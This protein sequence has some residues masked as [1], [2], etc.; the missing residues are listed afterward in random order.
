M[1]FEYDVYLTLS[2]AAVES[3]ADTAIINNDREMQRRQ[4]KTRFFGFSDGLRSPAII[5][6]QD[7]CFFFQMY[8][9]E[10]RKKHCQAKTE[11]DVNRLIAFHGASGFPRVFLRCVLG[12]QS[13]GENMLPSDGNNQQRL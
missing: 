3:D 13:S 8:I 5:K 12:G 4:I 1:S 6:N 2:R 10:I 11:T 7:S 9:Q